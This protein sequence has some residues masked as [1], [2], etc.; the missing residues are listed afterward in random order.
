MYSDTKN[1]PVDVPT[2]LPK[3]GKYHHLAEAIREG[4]KTTQK[5]YLSLEGNNGTQTCTLGAALVG[6]G[7]SLSYYNLAIHFPELDRRMQ[8]EIEKRN[9]RLGWS[10]EEIAD[11]LQVQ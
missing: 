3:F 6:I 2:E 11:W 10:R 5:C 1:F 7:K 4:C 8:Y 9:D